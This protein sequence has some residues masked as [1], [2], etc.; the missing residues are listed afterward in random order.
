MVEK[1]VLINNAITPADIIT[2]KASH[3]FS[4]VKTIYKTKS[5]NIIIDNCIKY[6]F[7]WKLIITLE[8][9]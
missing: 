2:L 9:T 3:L 6:Y 1:N 4:L 5:T 8:I 7:F